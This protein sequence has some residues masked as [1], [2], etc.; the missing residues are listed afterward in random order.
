MFDRKQ[1]F[2]SIR[3]IESNL[4]I[5]IIII[6]NVIFAIKHKIKLNQSLIQAKNNGFTSVNIHMKISNGMPQGTNPNNIN[7]IMHILE[8]FK[9]SLNDPLSSDY[10]NLTQ[11][12]QNY[13]ILII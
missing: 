13:V 8:D 12:I 7:L 6:I 3:D 4:Y 10:V 11:R 2:N 5:D 9:P 1:Y